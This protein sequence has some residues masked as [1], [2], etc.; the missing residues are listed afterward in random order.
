MATIR[1]PRPA[2]CF[3]TGSARAARRPGVRGGRAHQPFPHDVLRL[4]PPSRSRAEPT[5]PTATVRNANFEQ[6]T[7]GYFATL[8][9]EDARGPGLRRSTTATRGCRSRS[10]TPRLPRSTSAA[11]ARSAAASAPSATTASCSA[12]GARSSASSPTCACSGRSTIPNVDDTGFYVPYFS[13][14]LRPGPSR[15]VSAAVR[16]GGRPAARR[17]RPGHAVGHP[18]AAR[19]EQGRS[20]PP[21]LFR[22][23][24]A[25]QPSTRS[26]RRTASSPR[27]SPSSAGS[28]SCWPRSASTA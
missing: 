22:R 1:R 5:R 14:R 15:A 13:T 16:H 10:S 24:A 2:S 20:Q 8:G 4:R 21:P 11:R 25:G 19:G 18:A 28:P 17:R 23:H 26:S 6:V 12:R 9:R 3:S 7:D 27:C